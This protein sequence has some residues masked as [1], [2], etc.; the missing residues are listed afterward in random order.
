MSGLF[1]QVRLKIGIAFW[2]GL[3]KLETANSK[4]NQHG[5]VQN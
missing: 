3:L 1:E 2:A 5:A 4:Q